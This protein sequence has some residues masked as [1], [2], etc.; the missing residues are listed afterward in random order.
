MQKSHQGLTLIE[1]LTV[2]A[3]IAIAAAIA[4]PDFSIF[5]K[6]TKIQ[7]ASERFLQDMQAA[8]FES[9][10]RNRHIFVSVSA[11]S[12]WCFG[13]GTSASCNC[14]ANASACDISNA[15]STEYPGVSVTSSLSATPSTTSQYFDP[16]MGSFI[17]TATTCSP[18]V[19]CNGQVVFT[20]TGVAQAEVQ[21][22]GTGRSRLCTT[23]GRISGA[24]TCQ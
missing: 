10:K 5:A 7:S 16:V 3:I 21:L 13:V 6:R 22:F 1:L 18:S 12:S 9:V 17:G 23:S 8:K 19:A 4:L 14:S 15:G 24:P 20:Q 11:G 2:I